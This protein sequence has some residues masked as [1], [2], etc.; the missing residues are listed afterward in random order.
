MNLM[1]VGMHAVALALAALELDARFPLM[2]RA[3]QSGPV[4]RQHRLAVVRLSVRRAELRG[5]PLISIGRAIEI[6]SASF[7][8]RGRDRRRARA[9]TVRRGLPTASWS[10]TCASDCRT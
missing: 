4:V 6:D 2:I 9:R 7:S 8:C 10:D 5:A 1:P 3:P